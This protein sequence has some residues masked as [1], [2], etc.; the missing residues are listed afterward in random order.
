[1]TRLILAL[2]LS[3]AACA[4]LSSAKDPSTDLQAF[5]P[6]KDRTIQIVDVVGPSMQD[7]ILQMAYMAIES[8]DP[9][10]IMINSPGGYVS[11]GEMFM[12]AMAKMQSRGVVI[13][14][15]AN[16]AASMAMLILNQCD[17]RYVVPGARLL[18][19]PVKAFV[20]E[21]ISSRIAEKLAKELKEMDDYYRIPLRDKL[22][23]DDES[24]EKYR[25]EE[26]WWSVEEIMAYSPGYVTPVSSIEGVQ[27]DAPTPES[28]F[29]QVKIKSLDSYILFLIAPGYSPNFF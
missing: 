18:W 11:Y 21:A 25:W 29:G 27:W 13:K 19:H 10:Y 15:V 24:F 4:T 16:E 9:I 6:V 12:Q 5:T 3:L 17:E 22:G 8:N 7:K 14:C 1:M 23:V 2:A 28:P 20:R 26:K